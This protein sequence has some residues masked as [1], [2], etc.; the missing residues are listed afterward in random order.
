M[1]KKTKAICQVKGNTTVIIMSPSFKPLRKP[2]VVWH[3]KIVHV[4]IA[5]PRNSLVSKRWQTPK[6]TYVVHDELSGSDLI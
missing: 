1:I 3:D 4:F 2:I 6:R 5:L